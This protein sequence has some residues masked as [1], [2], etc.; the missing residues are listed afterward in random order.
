MEKAKKWAR[1]KVK[2]KEKEK[3]V[4]GRKIYIS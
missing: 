2:V 4:G 3:T 1:V